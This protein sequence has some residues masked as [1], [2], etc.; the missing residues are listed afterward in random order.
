MM[1]TLVLPRD[2]FNQAKLLKCLGKLSVMIHDGILDADQELLE[3][4]SFKVL[5][6]EENTLFVSNYIVSINGYDIPLYINYNSRTEYP[7]LFE[8]IDFSVDDTYVFNEKGQ[9]TKNFLE[10]CNCLRTKQD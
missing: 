5:L 1:Y 10:Y 4:D 8:P 6:S 7:L 3:D 2:F 9:L